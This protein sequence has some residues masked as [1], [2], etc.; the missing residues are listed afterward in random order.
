MDIK[1]YPKISVVTVNY[2]KGNL[3]EETICSVVNQ[4]YPNLE[5]IIID[6]GST[7]NSLKI[8]EKYKNHFSYFVTEPDKGATDALI[9]GF[10]KATGEILAWLNSDDTYMPYT[11]TFVAEQYLKHKFDFLYGDCLITDVNNNPIKR[12]K[13]YYTN[14]KAQALGIVPLYQPSCFWSSTIFQ[15]IGGLNPSF[16]VTMDGELFYRI[17]KYS[18]KT[19]RVNKV[20]S[21]FRI[22]QNQSNVWAP[23]GRYQLERRI[24]SEFEPITFLESFYYKFFFKTI[25]VLYR[26]FGIK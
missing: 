20:L 26:C 23:P 18:K 3:I 15:K 12:A 1:A 7:D 21:T 6:G 25:V 9:K 11:L 8:I 17:L 5:Y 22:H 10:K 19:I 16:F 2:N 13:S 24:I 14:Y 4:K